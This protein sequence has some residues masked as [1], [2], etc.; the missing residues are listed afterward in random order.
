MKKLIG[1]LTAFVTLTLS[2]SPTLAA[3]F[4]EFGYNR[5]ARNFVGTCLS[6]HM[7]KFSSTEAQALAYCGDWSNDKLVMKWNAEWD[8]GNIEGWS[9]PDG[10]DA[11]VNNEWNGRADGSGEVWKYKIVWVG[12]YTNNPG[13]VPDGAYG[14]WGQF[15]VLMDNG[16]TAENEHLLSHSSPAGYGAFYK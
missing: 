3:G 15:A 4:D 16:M 13:L 1:L 14:I 7:G 9:D 6:W 8:R 2:F 10:Y 11:W 5:T 12:N